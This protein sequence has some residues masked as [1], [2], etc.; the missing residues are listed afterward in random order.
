MKKK[1]LIIEDEISL[2][3]Q[4]KWGL[5]DAYDVVIAT[6]V[7]KAL[8]LIASREFPVIT[9]DLGLPPSP[10]TPQE[11]FRL[12]EEIPR[13]APYTKVIVITGNTEHANAVKAIGLGAT[14][15]C[16]K[17]IDHIG[18]LRIILE[19]T[20]NIYELEEA[21]RKLEQS[22]KEK[23]SLCGIMGISPVMEELF[24]LIRQSG[25][26]DHPVLIQGE[27]GTGKEMVAR[28]VHALSSRAQES[29]IIINCGAIPEN[30]MESELFGHEK[31]AFTGA[32]ST[33]VGKME[34]ADKGTVFLDEIG[35]LP[36]ML[37]VKLLRFLQ[38]GT[39]ERVGG[40]KTIKLNV[41]VIAATNVE[42]EKALEQGRFR[43]DLFYR[44]NVIPIIVPP[45]RKRQEDILFLAHHFIKE[46]SQRLHRGK[47]TL[48]QEAAAALTTHTW[49]G[50]VREL[51]NSICR[52][53]AIN[54]DGILTPA[55]LGLSG[56]VEQSFLT[57]K[58]ARDAAERQAIQH[59][60]AATENNITKAAKLLGISR[61]T[62]HD[63]LKKLGMEKLV[64]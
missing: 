63:L 38:E 7:P 34:L 30:L 48:S 51:K 2:G 20:F 44:L 41:K 4:L 59:A 6:D 26:T 16:T 42:L 5:S 45:L 57:I 23:Y 32:T 12:L 56:R 27:S 35:E 1:L 8:T 22:C 49:P 62:L 19:R 29:L 31:G 61:P 9:L 53:M 43:E 39:I 28:A 47:V 58:E 21:N 54:S 36:L 52:A 13:I 33:K 50:N 55:G 40:T 25:Y 10:D 18:I 14:D 24:K 15:F 37:Q 17:P 64:I 46:E 60:L 3:K 11:G